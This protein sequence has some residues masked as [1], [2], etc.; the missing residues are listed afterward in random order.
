[1][2]TVSKKD[3]ENEAKEVSKFIYLEIES[4]KSIGFFVG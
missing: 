1:M 2:S 3:I 4:I